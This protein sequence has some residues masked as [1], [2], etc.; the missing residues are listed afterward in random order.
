MALALLVVLVVFSFRYDDLVITMTLGGVGFVGGMV[1]WFY[2]RRSGVEK[3]L[4]LS[5]ARARSRRGIYDT[6]AI[7]MG[8][9]FIVLGIAGNLAS[10]PLTSRK[11]AGI[12]VAALTGA[13]LAAVAE[14][15][16]A[17][18]RINRDQRESDSN[19]SGS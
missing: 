13:T 10:G 17:K 8:V 11:L 4:E 14:R 16:L 18:R 5:S 15:W 2:L 9:L 3:E 19:Q 1:Q 12:V 6:K 7:M